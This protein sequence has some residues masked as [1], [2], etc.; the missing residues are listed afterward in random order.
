MKNSNF[1][2]QDNQVSYRTWVWLSIKIM[3]FFVI[4]EVTVQIEIPRHSQ[5]HK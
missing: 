3:E 2:C 1:K 5:K 4:V